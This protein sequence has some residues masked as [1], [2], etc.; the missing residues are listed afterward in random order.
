MA[1]QHQQHERNGG[2]LMAV[3]GLGITLL[4]NAVTV[5]YVYGGVSTRL[6]EAESKLSKFERKVDDMASLATDMAVVKTQL[7]AIN[8][9]LTTLS[10]KLDA[11]SK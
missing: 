3:I 6:Q 8:T 5:G 1:K 10:T 2:Q 9:T 11:R 4:L 7:G